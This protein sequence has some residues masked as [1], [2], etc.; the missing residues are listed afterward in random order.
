MQKAISLALIAPGS[1]LLI[2]GYNASQSISSEVT[3]V[4]T[5]LPADKVIW[6]IGG[7]AAATIAGIAGLFPDKK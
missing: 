6:L 7:G 1:V 3:R 2:F 4:L 5:G